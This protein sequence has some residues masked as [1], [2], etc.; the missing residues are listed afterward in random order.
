MLL[1]TVS[2]PVFQ[3]EQVFEK[4]LSVDNLGILQ[5][6]VLKERKN[7]PKFVTQ[8]PSGEWRG[9]DIECCDKT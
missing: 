3:K 6:N 1:L 8:L 7:L 2:V 4:I 5:E 9:V